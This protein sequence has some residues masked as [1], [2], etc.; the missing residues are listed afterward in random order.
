MNEPPSTTDDNGR[1]NRGR[2]AAG[3]KAARGN[4]YSRRAARLRAELFRECSPD[5]FRDIVRALI[6]KA[7][8]G[9]LAA[10][11]EVFDRI[12]GKATEGAD[13]LARLD[14]LEAQADA[15]GNI[16]RATQ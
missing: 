2:F 14:A 12:I 1:D 8:D 15:A 16:E 11:R 7:R 13:L 6:L 10:I 4:P 9:D 3:N 5:D